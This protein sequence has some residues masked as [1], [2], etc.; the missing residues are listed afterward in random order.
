[1]TCYEAAVEYLALGFHPIPCAPRS[2]RPLVQWRQ[3]QTEPPRL[4]DLDTWWRDTPDANVAL[5]LGRGTFAVD[6]DG[7]KAA[8][9]LLIQQG[10]LLPAAPRSKTGHGGHVFLSCDR[11][12]PDR[13]GL[14]TTN[15]KKPQ[16]DIRGVGIVVAPPSIHPDG[17]I[18]EW[19]APLHVP[20]PAAP[21]RLLQLIFDHIET[22]TSGPMGAGWVAEALMGLPRGTR[23]ATCT[24]LAGYFLGHGLPAELVE[25]LLAETFGPRCTPPFP[26]ADIRKCVQSIARKE[27]LAEPENGERA[28]TPIPLAQALDDLLHQVRTGP[29]P[30]VPAPFPT[31]NRFLSGGFSA[32]ELVYIGARAG[33]GKTSWGLDLV[34]HAAAHGCPALVISREMLTLA[35]ARRM[36]AQGA[37][38]RASSLK[39]GDIEAGEWW[40][41]EQALPRLKA[42]P[43]WLTDAAVTI[44]EIERAVAESPIPLRLLVV[45]YLQLVHAP[46]D[47]RDRRLQV[48]AVSQALKTLAVSARLAVVCLSSLARS[49]DKEQRPTLA[50]LRESGELE[51]DADVVLLLHR[52]PMQAET[53]CIVAKNRDGRQGIVKLAF[54]ADF[55]TFDEVAE[56]DKEIVPF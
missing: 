28:V 9:D 45:D 13:V 17:P 23:D 35:L 25:T 26:Q 29:A 1:M 52:A 43:V 5:V 34:R 4:E 54:R 20:L 16:V 37:R 48:E 27:R 18:Y 55:V 46:R 12:V 11:P 21:P 15:G 50:S 33:V 31:L 38:V 10:V 40:Q 14:L 36:L 22:P 6:L 53:E 41:I 19:I 32:G 47:I 51:H 49:Q 7:G 56:R 8:E 30:V 2:K 39:T 42:L 3:Y 24:Q 44:G